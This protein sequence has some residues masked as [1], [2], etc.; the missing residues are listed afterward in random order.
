M[1]MQIHIAKH[2][3]EFEEPNGYVR[4]MT[5]GAGEVCNPT[6]RTTIST[7][8]SPQSSQGLNHQPKSTYGGTHNSSWMCS[9]GLPY[10]VPMGGKPLCPVEAPRVRECYGTE[11]GVGEHPGRGRGGGEDRGLWRGELGREIIFEI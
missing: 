5:E 6:G 9:R 4:A 3:T 10:L 2:Q 11:V 1:L 7:N 8:Q